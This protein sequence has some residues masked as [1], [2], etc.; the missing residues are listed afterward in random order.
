MKSG[1]YRIWGPLSCG[2]DDFCLQGSLLAVRWKT[3]DSGI[4]C[5]LL[6]SDFLFGLFFDSEDDAACYSETSV[7][8][9]RTIWHIPEDE[10]FKSGINYI[11]FACL[12][13]TKT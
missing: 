11:G 10:L 9:Q 2:Y 4:A 7:D 8:F 3:T 13:T 1:I 6:H 5:N 12:L